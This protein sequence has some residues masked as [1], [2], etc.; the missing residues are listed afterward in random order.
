MSLNDRENSRAKAEP[1]ELF[2]LQGVEPPAENMLRAVVIGNG[3]EYGFGTTRVRTSTGVGLCEVAGQEVADFVV[4]L[5]QLQMTLPN[6]ERVCLAVGWHGDDLRA[7]ICTIKPKVETAARSTEPY[8]W[9]V[10]PIVR[11]AAGVVSQDSGLPVFPG[12]PSDRSIYQAILEIKRRGLKVTVCPIIHLDIPTGNARPDPYSSALSQPTHPSASRITCHPAPGRPGSPDKTSGVLTHVDSFFGSVARTAFGWEPTGRWVTYSGSASEWSYR[13]FVLHLATIAAA[14]GGVDDFLLG[15]D[16]GGITTLRSAA[17]TY[18]SVARLRTL[19]ADVRA[20]LGA[21]TR[22][23]YAAGWREYN[24]H[25]PDDGSGDVY[26][27]LDPFWADANVDFVGIN[28]YMPLSDWRNG[29]THL[30]RVAGYTSIYDSD[31]LRANI[32]GGEFFDWTYADTAAR[33]TQARTPI[34]DPVY[35][36]PWVFRDKDL[37]NWWLNTHRDR[38]AG[39]RSG[40]PTAWTAAMKP[41]VFTEFGCAAVDKGT[42]LPEAAYLPPVNARAPFPYFS[43]A[44][45]DESIQRAYLETMLAYWTAES[46]V[47]AADDLRMIDAASMFAWRWDARP[48]SV[49]PR[50]SGRW[51]DTTQ[52]WRSHWLNGRLRI[53]EAT[54][55]VRFGPYAFTTAEEPIT[56]HG[57]TY[58]PAPVT[59]EALAASGTLDKSTL[60]VTIARGFDQDFDREFVA[61]PPMCIV[62]L[63]IFQGHAGDDPDDPASFACA[64]AGKVQG[65]T[66]IGRATQL[67]VEPIS[68]SMRRNGL[69]MNFQ[70]GCPHV[71]YGPQ[72]RASKAAATFEVTVASV[73]SDGTVTLTA[74][75]PGGHGPQAFA[76]GMIEWPDAD[77]EVALRTIARVTANNQFQVRGFI[78]DLVPGTQARITFGCRHTTTACREVHHNILN[79]GGQPYIPLDNP[80]GPRNQFF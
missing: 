28:N 2:L 50:L 71:L 48:Y 38:P 17:G 56:R 9:R 33:N 43:N 63:S 76:G 41:V 54:S 18:P 39:V 30:D 37:R 47:R 62:N 69:R 23:S 80:L 12:A 16:L 32:E 35:G 24:N 64:W 61:Y 31:Y 27:H 15:S 53:G 36:E 45:G 34:S 7:T 55:A 26:F 59:R 49:F 11:G 22:I 52:W 20:M 8:E 66:K 25:R 72:C 13:R 79:Y 40:S 75:L 3:G 57:I 58:I 19:A 42:N 77:N 51:L 65:A 29:N 6:V 21:G 46:P 67:T 10:G 78:T 68:V 73:A 74:N 44:T 1:V 14:A 4:A 5:D 70:R 60:N